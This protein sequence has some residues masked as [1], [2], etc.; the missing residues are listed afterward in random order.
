LK[1][2]WGPYFSAMIPNMWLTEGGQSVTGIL[3]DHIISG[4]P[5]ISKVKEMATAANTSGISE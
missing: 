4:H 5:S 3:I 1:G 2:I